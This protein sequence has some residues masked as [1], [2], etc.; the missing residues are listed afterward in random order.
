[1][2][3]IKPQRTTRGVVDRIEPNGVVFVHELSTR[4]I[5][6]LANTTPVVGG[7]VGSAHLKPGTELSLD[8]VDR[9]DV[10]VVSAA[11]LIGG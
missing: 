2:T 7:V 3:K 5:G 9:G 1:M 11:R 8:V 4:K 10:M 6:Y